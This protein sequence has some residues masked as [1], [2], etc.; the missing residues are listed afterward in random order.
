[1]SR[2]SPRWRFKHGTPSR[3]RASRRGHRRPPRRE[4]TASS[5]SR[6]ISAGSR[7]KSTSRGTANTRGQLLPDRRWLECGRVTGD[8]PSLDLEEQPH[9]STVIPSGPNV[10]RSIHSGIG[11]RPITPFVGFR[12]TKLN[13]P[14]GI[15]I[16]PPPSVAVAIGAIPA[17]VAAPE[18]PEEP[19]GRRLEVPGFGEGRKGGCRCSRRTRTPA[20]SSSRPR[21]RRPSGAPGISPSASAGRGVGEHRRAVRRRDALDVLHVLDQDRD[22]RERSGIVAT[23]DPLVERARLLDRLLAGP[24]SPPRSRGSAVRSAP[25]TS[26]PAP[27]LRPVVLEP[28]CRVPPA[29]GGAYPTGQ[30]GHLRRHGPGPFG[31]QIASCSRRPATSRTRCSSARGRVRGNRR[32]DSRGAAAAKRA[33]LD[34]DFHAINHAEAD[35]G[36]GYDLFQQM[37]IGQW[38]RATGA[39]GTSWRP[40]IP[41]AAGSEEQK[42]RFLRPACR[43]SAATRTRSRRRPPAPTRRWSRRS[44]PATATRG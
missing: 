2:A 44:R 42:D 20:G 22:P 31:R 14:A 36:R 7:P 39:H 33:V 29:C 6:W 26:G 18:P 4:A 34:W 1:M 25:A 37:L 43:G 8:R 9:A 30:P 5:N 35:G 41:L 38:G 10:D 3:S 27:R 17:A 28:P 32:P 23:A 15:R 16:E 13:Q 11:Q 12:P 19:A 21:S 40:S 24:R